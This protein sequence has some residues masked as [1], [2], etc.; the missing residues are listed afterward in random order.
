M[1]K[2]I[3]KE[4]ILE[5]LRKHKPSD[6]KIDKN[7]I[8]VIYGTYNNVDVKLDD[9]FDNVPLPLMRDLG[10]LFETTAVYASAYNCDEVHGTRTFQ[11]SI[12][13]YF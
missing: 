7:K 13:I 3:T 2:N 5:V 11:Y 9:Y 8:E 6:F 1:T 12:E 4:Q 10:E